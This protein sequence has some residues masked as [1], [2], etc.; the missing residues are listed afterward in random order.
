MGGNTFYPVNVPEAN[1][2]IC[3]S[4]NELSTD[5]C[6]DWCGDGVRY[7][8]PY[9]WNPR[10]NMQRNMQEFCDDGNNKDGDGC[11]SRCHVEEGFVCE[12]EIDQ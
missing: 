4:G 3:E 10:R 5:W 11:D 1:R 8:D 6:H 12:D 2:H 9:V 7:D